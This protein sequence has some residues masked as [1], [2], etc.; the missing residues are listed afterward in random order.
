M[1]HG[2][3]PLKMKGIKMALD[4]RFFTTLSLTEYIVDPITGEPVNGGTISFFEDTSRSTPKLAYQLTGSPPNYTYSELPNSM[5]IAVGQPV[6]EDG[7][8][9]AIY[10]YPY[11]ELGNLQLYYVAIHNEAGDLIEQR[12]A[13]PNI[14]STDDP[15][16]ANNNISNFLSNSQFSDVLFNPIYGITFTIS[17]SV[18][19]AEYDIA[20]GWF[21]RVST[22]GSATITINRTALPGS[23]NLET[24]PPFQ[25]EILSG[26]G[27]LTSL[28]LVQQLNNNPDIW[29]NQYLSGGFLVSSLDGVSHPIQMIYAPSVTTANIVVITAATGQT[30][31]VYL[32]NTVLL[33]PG[34]NTDTGD[35]GYVEIQ[36][37]LPVSGELAITSLQVVGMASNQ[38]DVQYEQEPVNRQKDH[39]F[40]YYYPYIEQV[41]V[42]SVTQGWDFKV[43]PTQWGSAF[44]ATTGPSHYVWDQTI[45]WQSADNLFSAAKD[46]VGELNIALAGTGQF[47]LI[48]YIS[49]ADMHVLLANGWSTVVNGFTSNSLGASGTVSFWYTTDMNLPAT[50]SNLSLVLTMDA[51]GKPATFNGN[52]TEFPNPQIGNA[53]FTLPLS[54]TYDPNPSVLNG[55]PQPDRSIGVSATYCAIVVGFSSLPAQTVRFDSIAVTPGM[56]ARPFA[57]LSYALTLQQMQYYW[58]QSYTPGVPPGTVTNVNMKQSLQGA[59][60]FGS[61][62]LASTFNLDYKTIKI[63]SSPINTLYNP[64][65]ATPGLV[66]V[67]GNNVTPAS[68]TLSTF[69][70]PNYGNSSTQYVGNYSQIADASGSI[71]AYLNYQYTINARLGDV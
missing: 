27:N 36:I 70:S 61:N 2:F 34:D 68:L 38:E 63:S 46:G 35:T 58:E 28:M 30:D 42:P 53:K 40:H 6:N 44:S 4:N 33:P 48:Q 9:T 45:V 69:W 14:T 8:P 37:I 32:T 67:T 29:A 71:W 51:N 65:S 22:N 20:P 66:R 39:L 62:I 24:N 60:S 64:V 16:T 12:E 19:N 11:D 57:P 56:L 21:L 50:G 18:T 7:V 43:N 10:Y 1:G 13:V 15:V 41:P 49:M 5:D 23:L 55:W 54:S 25:L 31:Y 17:G 52:W 59:G 26:G 47:A 3:W